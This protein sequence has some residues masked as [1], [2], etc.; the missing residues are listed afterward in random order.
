MS[1][2]PRTAHRHQLPPDRF[3]WAVV[4]IPQT[5]PR[6][7]SVQQLCYFFEAALPIPLEDVHVVFEPLGEGRYLGCALP[8]AQLTQEIETL[9]SHITVLTPSAVPDF[10]DVNTHPDTLNLLTGDFEPPVVKRLRRRAWSSAAACLALCAVFIVLGLELRAQHVHRL[11]R[12]VD[13]NQRAV[14][15]Q[16]L[17]SDAPER[18]QPL[19]LQMRSLLRQLQQ[20]RSASALD[21][22]P[23]QGNADDTLATLLAAWPVSERDNDPAL[24]LRTELIS[25][26]PTS[27]TVRGL[28]PGSE[29]AQALADAMKDVQGWQLQ[30]PQIVNAGD[31]VQATLQFAR[32]DDQ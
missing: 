2:S 9:G 26:T 25:V 3:F 27:I 11:T 29:E 7:P 16:V 28:L 21:D 22:E 4:Q 31:A 19:E 24:H 20:T 13:A 8:R 14:Q 30:Q 18:T 32:K 6:R 10:L 17:G 12:A 1:G 15:V 5:G 23:V